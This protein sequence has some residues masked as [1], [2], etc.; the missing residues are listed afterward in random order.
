MNRITF[1]VTVK[2]LSETEAR[3]ILIT[4]STEGVDRD[5]DIIDVGGWKTDQYMKNPVILWAHDRSAPPVAK[6]L[7]VSVDKNKKTLDFKVYFPTIAELS[8]IPGTP[9]EHALFVDTLYNMYKNGLLNASSVGFRAL[10]STTREDQDLP[11]WARGTHFLEQELVEL[12]LV[13]VPANAEALVRAREIKE[14]DP[15]GVDMV[16]KAVAEFDIRKATWESA[17]AAMGALLDG[18]EKKTVYA[19][20]AKIYGAFDEEPPELKEEDVLSKEE[21]E[22]LKAFAESLDVNTKSNR[23]L[24]AASLARVNAAIESAKAA[25]KELTELVSEGAEEDEGDKVGDGVEEPLGDGREGT[26][27][28]KKAV[29]SLEGLSLEDMTNILRTRGDQKGV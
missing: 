12:S 6:A 1:P 16:V 25:L 7:S 5:G 24:S 17:K 14:I 27:P 13:P 20:I 8:S 11:T 18:A 2:D 10:K 15:A 23:K 26:D 9:S 3:S 21:V 22:R 29:T 4:G 19:H 28:P